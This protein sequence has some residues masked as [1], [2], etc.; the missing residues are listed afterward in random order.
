MRVRRRRSRLGQTRGRVRS[1]RRPT[2]P[3]HCHRCGGTNGPRCSSP[4]PPAPRW[5]RPSDLVVT[6]D[7]EPANASSPAPIRQCDALDVRRQLRP[8]SPRARR[9]AR[10]HRDGR[11]T[12]QPTVVRYTQA[13][14]ERQ[15]P[16]PQAPAR[17]PRLRRPRPRRRRRPPRRR[18]RRPL[19]DSHDDHHHADLD[20]HVDQHA[21]ECADV[22]YY[23]YDDH[24][25]VRRRRVRHRPRHPP[26]L[27]VRGRTGPLGHG[28]GYSVR[29]SLN[30]GRRLRG[31]RF[32]R[33]RL[34]RVR[35]V[36]VVVAARRL[37]VP[38]VSVLGGGRCRRRVDVGGHRR[39]G[40]GDGLGR[41]WSSTTSMCRSSSR[42][43]RRRS[44]AGACSGS[45]NSL[46]HVRRQQEQDAD[47]RPEPRRWRRPRWTCARATAGR[48]GVV[49][50]VAGHGH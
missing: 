31:R 38:E 49:V 11:R 43:A 23:S 2:T 48:V 19:D 37:S 36:V 7:T 26:S 34:V 33:R 12:G 13:P 47:A 1:R 50:A 14:P 5:S 20:A 3:T 4:R 45:L 16:A 35:R 29:V 28:R 10:R 44:T 46:G 39:T 24:L 9:A 15:A 18:R 30:R 6:T 27:T 21:D 32:A 40:A 17:H 22:D 41:R 42:S 8:R 25:D